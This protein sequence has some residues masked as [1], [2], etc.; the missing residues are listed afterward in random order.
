MY[1]Y[2]LKVEGMKCPNCEKHASQAI[3][4]A[5]SVKKVTASHTD[6]EVIVESKEELD[7]EKIKSVIKEAG[8]EVVDISRETIK[9]GLKLW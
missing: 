1:R 5:F 4:E 3:K 7:D 6:K 8:Y 2:M 9:K